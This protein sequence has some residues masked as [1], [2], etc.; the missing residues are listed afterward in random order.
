[1]E[2]VTFTNQLR[3]IV[4]MLFSP[5]KVFNGINKAPFWLTAYLF[6]AT[7]TIIIR[8]LY[9][10]IMKQVSFVSFSS[11]FSSEQLRG[12]VQTAKSFNIISAA[13]S[14]I[15]LLIKF[16]IIALLLWLMVMLF[17]DKVDFEKIFSLV[18]H[19]GIITFAGSVL[20]LIILQL[21]GLH[22]IE[23]ATDVQVSLGL[24]IFLRN[25]DLNLPFKTFLSNINLFSVWWIVLITLGIS[26]TSKISRIKSA[27]VAIFFWI[28]ST[29]VQ[30]GI[31]SL[32]GSLGNIG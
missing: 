24:D 19:C 15:Y 28:F 22:S 9:F 27:F 30:I 1:M 26:I 4:D 31:A 5:S 32:L 14:P 7:G 23:K 29:A 25:P 8:I 20:S 13:L 21:R 17:S 12:I 16:I 10:P 2:K 18:V 6:I 3:N 11:E